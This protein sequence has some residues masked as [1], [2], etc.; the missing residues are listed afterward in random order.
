L[1]I[2]AEL[3]V[4][5]A[6]EEA[7]LVERAQRGEPD[8]YEVLVRRHQELA[9]RVAYLITQEAAEAEDAAQEAFIKAYYNLHRFRPGASFRAWLLRIVVNQAR[10][11]RKAA[12][13]QAGLLS[14]AALPLSG[15]AAPSPEMAALASEQRQALLNAISRLREGDRLIL[16]YRFFFDLSEAEIA[17]A[18]GCARGTVKSRLSRALARL[19][20][21]LG[22]SAAG[23]EKRLHHD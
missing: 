18:L 10:N 9:Q 2:D 7:E 20:H 23:G 17:A 6:P 14:R 1:Y 3:E 21:T 19:R 12:R 16:A 5:T 4:A 8:A 15:H 22:S 13:R 11:R